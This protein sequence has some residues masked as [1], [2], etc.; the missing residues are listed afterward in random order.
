MTIHVGDFR[1]HVCPADAALVLVD[2]PF[3]LGK[4]YAGEKEK[5]IGFDTYVEDLVAWSTAPWTLIVSPPTTMRDWL[6][7]IP[8]PTRI[9]WWCKTFAQIR[10]T[11][12]WQHAVTPVLVYM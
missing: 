1:T 8:P 7:R 10:R 4:V 11:T 2:P 5:R 6:P 9:L 3:A 12:T